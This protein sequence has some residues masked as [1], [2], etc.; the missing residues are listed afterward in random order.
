[1]KEGNSWIINKIMNQKPLFF[2]SK[3][4]EYYKGCKLKHSLKVH[5]PIYPSLCFCLITRFFFLLSLIFSSLFFFQSFIFYITFFLLHSFFLLFFY[6]SF[7]LCS[8]SP[9]FFFYNYFK[10]YFLFSFFLQR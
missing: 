5:G 8:F 1:M 9:P 4:K 7:I 6:H 10:T 2:F 3:H